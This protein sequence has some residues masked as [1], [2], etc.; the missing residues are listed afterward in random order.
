MLALPA[1]QLAPTSQ[2]RQVMTVNGLIGA[3]DMGL[4]PVHEHLCS[5][6]RSY[7]DPVRKKIPVDTAEVVEVVLPYLTAIREF[8]CRTLIDCT[9]THLGRHPELIKRLSDA[10]GLH[11]LTT[12]GN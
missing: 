9:A 10:S 5:D 1:C 11:M 3:H 4:T 12:T 6:L 8:G 2:R 7:E